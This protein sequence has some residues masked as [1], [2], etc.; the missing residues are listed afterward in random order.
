[1]SRRDS[2]P[3]KKNLSFVA[4]MLSVFIEAHFEEIGI[5]A[6][7]EVASNT[8]SPSD[9]LSM[10]DTSEAEDGL[11]LEEEELSSEPPAFDAEEAEVAVDSF[12]TK[13]FKRRLISKDQQGKLPKISQVLEGWFGE[14]DEIVAVA[15]SFELHIEGYED[16]VSY[17]DMQAAYNEF[18]QIRDKIKREAGEEE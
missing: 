11:I 15:E 3:S 12:L 18:V 17:E 1:M 16:W 7:D 8:A 10:D 6:S 14:S 5:G 2:R 9:R 4:E 13:L